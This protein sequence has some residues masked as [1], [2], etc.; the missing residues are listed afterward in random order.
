MV[1]WLTVLC[2]TNCSANIV[3]I[4]KGRNEGLR[5]MGVG[6]VTAKMLIDPL[7]QCQQSC[8]YIW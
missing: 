1:Q 7:L 8:K 4:A 2:F 5:N 3:E 6:F